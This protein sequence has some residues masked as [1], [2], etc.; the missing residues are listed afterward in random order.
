[1]SRMYTSCLSACHLR[2][3]ELNILYLWDCREERGRIPTLLDGDR[4]CYVW[5]KSQIS[6]QAIDWFLTAWHA[7]RQKATWM[8]IKLVALML[9]GHKLEAHLMEDKVTHIKSIRIVTQFQCANGN[10]F[11][12]THRRKDG[13]VT[14]QARTLCMEITTGMFTVFPLLLIFWDTLG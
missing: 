2:Q 14:G 10:W 11:K 4:G 12:P 5:H 1:M 3:Q 6:L 13:T 8:L 7:Y 9:H